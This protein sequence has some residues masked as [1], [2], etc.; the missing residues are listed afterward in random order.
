MPPQTQTLLEIPPSAVNPQA[1]ALEYRLVQVYPP[2]LV[3]GMWKLGDEKKTFGRD[4]A[5]SISIA[6]AG[7]SRRHAELVRSDTGFRITDTGSTNGTFVND[8]PI[9]SHD[10][11]TG[12]NIRV[13]SHIFKFLATGSMEAKYHETVYGMMTRDALTQAFNKQYLLDAIENEI[14]RVNRHRR[15]FCVL[16]MDID[17]FKGVNDKY[18]HL[19]GDEVLREFARRVAM[20]TRSGDTFA[21]FGGE[22][23]TVLAS[24]CT[25]DDAADY[26]ERIRIAIGG[27]PFP[28]ASGPLA[29]TVSLGVFEYDGKSRLTI[30]EILNSADEKLYD[31]KENGR[32]R[33]AV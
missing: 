10:L 27:T 24:E 14:S 1:P 25:C 19:V 8:E 26:A 6:E 16:M 3:D 15:P 33:V 7:V 13:G 18:G 20:Q 4:P 2:E 21:R 5:C 17:H 23:F 9:S 11:A 29:V 22:E 12:D 31:A 32:N 28:T 30:D